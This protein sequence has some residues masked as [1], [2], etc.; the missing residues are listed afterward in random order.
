[1]SSHKP[2]DSIKIVNLK[3][4]EN[5]ILN[6][7]FY[8]QAEKALLMLSAVLSILVIALIVIIYYTKIRNKGQDS[9]DDYKDKCTKIIGLLVF[10]VSLILN[11]INEKKDRNMT[12]Y[13]NYYIDKKYNKQDVKFLGKNH[14]RYIWNDS[15]DTYS[16]LNN[17]WR[18]KSLADE[19]DTTFKLSERESDNIHKR[20]SMLEGKTGLEKFKK[21]TVIPGPP[22]TSNEL[23]PVEE[24][25]EN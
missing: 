19:I 14:R 6:S 23:T 5:A 17:I 25:T 15:V 11:F 22:T 1:M 18:E 13:V 9:V 21:N 8:D 16:N 4:D 10:S 20:T 3:V 24:Y 2:N 7:Y 12:A